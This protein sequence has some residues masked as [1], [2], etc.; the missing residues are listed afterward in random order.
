MSLE[1]LRFS[2]EEVYEGQLNGDPLTLSFSFAQ[3]YDDAIG[4]DDPASSATY[5]EYVTITDDSGSI[6]TEVP[7][8]WADVDGSPNPDI[9][10]SLHAAP[11]LEEFFTTFS[12]PGVAIDATSSLNM[13]DID[14]VLDSRSYADSCT[15][16]GR[17]PYSDPLYA[18]SLDTWTDCGGV[19]AVLFV[20]G[21]TPADGSYLAFI[22]IQAVEERDLDA[23]DQIL[24]T[25]IASP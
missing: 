6:T 11:N 14:S 24:A 21:V 17:T 25:F 16:L 23:A 12:T 1:V 3:S 19:G 10:P 7:V 22:E 15:Y 8:E 5:T 20:L 2:T 4:S 18:G 13:N 9:G